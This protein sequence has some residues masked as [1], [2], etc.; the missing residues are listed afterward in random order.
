MYCIGDVGVLAESWNYSFVRDAYGC[1]PIG[2]GPLNDH[3]FNG[4]LVGLICSF[5][6]Y[7]ESFGLGFG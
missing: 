3:W 5:S 1:L 6:V 2:H 7:V 4:V